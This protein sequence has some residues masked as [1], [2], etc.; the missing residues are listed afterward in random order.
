MLR[1]V[2]SSRSDLPFCVGSFNWLIDWSIDR[3]IDR[4]VIIE[5]KSARE[6][7]LIHAATRFRKLRADLRIFCQQIIP[8]RLQCDL[9]FGNVLR[10]LIQLVEIQERNTTRKLCCRKDDHAMR[11]VYG[12]R[13]NLRGSLTTVS[14]WKFIF[15]R[16][17]FAADSRC[18]AV[19]KFPNNF[20]WK[21]DC[22]FEWGL[23]TPNV[24][25]GD[26]GCV[27]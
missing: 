7:A 18:V 1:C 6:H 10:R 19:C 14:E 21:P 9:Q 24:G 16:Y 3:S 22:S 4:L 11:P 17:I 5:W 20:V 2:P 8:D 12:C 25:E 27:E 23:W 13:K 15:L 26:R